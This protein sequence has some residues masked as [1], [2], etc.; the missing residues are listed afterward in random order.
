MVGATVEKL[1]SEAWSY[2]GWY[3]FGGL[4]RFEDGYDTIEGRRERLGLTT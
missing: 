2:V 4:K 3:N 1:E